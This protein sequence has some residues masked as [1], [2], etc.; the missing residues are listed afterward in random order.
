[1]METVFKR[2]EFLEALARDPSAKRELVDRINVSRSTVNRGVQDLEQFG[3]VEYADGGYRLTVSGRLMYEQYT[4]YRDSAVSVAATADLLELLPKDAPISVD[5]LRD[6][7]VF[8]AEDPAP[9]VPVTVLSK[10]VRECDY[11]RG[12]SRS[13]AAPKTADALRDAI[14]GGAVAEIVFREDVYEHVREAYAW[15]GDRIVDGDLRPYLIDDVPYGLV[16]AEHADRVYSCLV[17]YD[18]N[19]GIGGVLVNETQAAFNWATDTFESY[20]DR[21]R[22]VP[23]LEG[24]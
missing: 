18:E 7:D 8:V 1:M 19:S 14:E 24:D 17:V 23:K 3:L 16:I 12:F 22:I 21:A 2:V 10:I 4:R 6:A 11:L 13:H 15:F 9:H 5:L 20:R